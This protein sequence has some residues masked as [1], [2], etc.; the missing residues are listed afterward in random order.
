MV[1]KDKK[2]AGVQKKLPTKSEVKN[3]NKCLYKLAE[4]SSGNKKVVKTADTVYSI[5][6]EIVNES[7]FKKS[8]TIP[9]SGK[10]IELKGELQFPINLNL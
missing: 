7:V 9:P 8:K 3:I 2:T 4:E 10:P 6:N 5:N 1:R